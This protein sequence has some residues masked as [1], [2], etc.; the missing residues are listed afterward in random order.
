MVNSSYLYYRVHMMYYDNEE[1]IE[2]NIICTIVINIIII[3]QM[4][5][6]LPSFPGIPA[7]HDIMSVALSA[8][9]SFF[10]GLA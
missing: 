2:T 6:I 3:N 8:S 1:H 5:I 4:I 7:S 10:I 9:P